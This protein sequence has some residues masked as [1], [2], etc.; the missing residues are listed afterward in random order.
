MRSNLDQYIELGDY[1]EAADGQ[2]YTFNGTQ[3]RAQFTT[4]QVMRLTQGE[5]PSTIPGDIS[6]P[7]ASMP[8][9]KVDLYDVSYLLSRWGSTNT[10]NLQEAD[11]SPG[12]SNV[13]QD[14]I[15]LYDANLIMKNWS[16]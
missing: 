9:N 8:D 4:Y 2:S 12:P 5:P 16:P 3:V 13:S 6:G 11:I 15:D 7:T 14:K 1:F 10:Q